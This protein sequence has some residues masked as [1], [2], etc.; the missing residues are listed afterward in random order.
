MPLTTGS[1]AGVLTP[2]QVHELLNALIEGA[3]FA[4]S[5]TRATTSTGKLAFPTVAPTG[6]SW[7][8]EL[9]E[10]PRLVIDDKSLIVAV[11]KII[12]GLPISAVDDER[13]ERERDRLGERSPRRLALP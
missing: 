8:A 1:F 10:V 2:A 11:K 12:G 5:L 7:L 4:G 3:P 6:Y 13:R 9:A